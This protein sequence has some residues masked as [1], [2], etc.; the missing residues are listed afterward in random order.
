MNGIRKFNEKQKHDIADE[1]ISKIKNYESKMTTRLSRWVE[2]AELYQGKS[3]TT[4][5]NSKISSNSAELFKSIRAIRNMMMRM[6]LGTKPSFSLSANDALAYE[7]PDRLIKAEHYVSQQMDL[8]NYANGLAGAIDSLLL[9]GTVAVHN[10]Y[11]PIRAPHLGK[12]QYVT[13]FRPLS[14]INCAFSLD[15]YNISECGWVG[16]SDIQSKKELNKLLSYDPE[17]KIYDAGE[18]NKCLNDNDYTPEVNVWV[19]QRL[20]WQG[21]I[22][23][24]F[25]GGME[26]VTYYGPLDCLD[27]GQEYC[28]EVVNRQYV[29][30]SE[31]YSGLRPVRI[32]AINNLPPEPLGNGMGDM[33]RPIL[34]EI[35]DA[36]SAMLN[37]ITLAGASMFRMQKDLT[38]EDAEFYIRQFGIAR[39]QNPL[40]PIGPNPNNLLAVAQFL[41]DRIQAYRQASGATDTLQAIVSGEQST[42]TATSL[43]MNE[44]VRN[45]SLMSELCAPYLH[46]DY[47]KQILE[48]AQK[49]NTGPMTVPI[50]GVPVEVLPSELLIDANVNIK[51]ST[52]Q[53]FRPAKLMR[54]REG[55]QVGA[56]FGQALASVG[57]K[58]NPGPIITEY[59][60][61]LDI[62]D[63]SKVIEDIT[64]DDMLKGRMMAEMNNPAPAEQEEGA[65]TEEGSKGEKR[66][67]NGQVG[68][69]ERRMLNR[70]MS[71]P[72]TGT[73]TTPV[74]Q[75]LS[76]PG[77]QQSTT[78]AIRQSTTGEK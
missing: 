40:E 36:K 61:D 58:F 39:T 6:I 47:V 23:Q 32:A 44:S 28:I 21:Y 78:K 41:Q 57:K 7:Y 53:D 70:N 17:G 19:T 59:F 67:A 77:D 76:A 22:N 49:Y 11:E 65:E 33:F 12:K 30:R 31:A 26:R 50:Q 16:L 14:L 62:P 42:A 38:D 72:M 35:D 25:Y 20:A 60:K 8:A 1:V 10:P 29:I 45:V 73:M 4:A 64:E 48:N 43:A 15:S 3:A 24:K 37:M 56:M 18:I 75:V 63:Y 2:A 52:D 54:M 69:R 46:R 5:T 9:Y 68:R 55:L 27:D 34:G 71:M 13:Q 66:V 51:T 74:G